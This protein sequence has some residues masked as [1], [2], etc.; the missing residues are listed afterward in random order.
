LKSLAA[1]ETSAAY[2]VSSVQEKIDQA[3]FY[4]EMK[5]SLDPAQLRALDAAVRYTG[6]VPIRGPFG[7]GKTR[8]IAAIIGVILEVFPN[9][10]IFVTS[11]TNSAID[12]DLRRVVEDG[13]VPHDRILRLGEPP[14]GIES[15]Y[16]QFFLSEKVKKQEELLGRTLHGRALR[17]RVRCYEE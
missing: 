7:C 8:L 1:R 2:C 5:R 15:K 10:R 11:E 13:V 12:E 6:I 14:R 3:K 16:L 4:Q 17:E 9:F